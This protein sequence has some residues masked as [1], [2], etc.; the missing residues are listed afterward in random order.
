MFL[1]KKKE[2]FKQGPVLYSALS[3]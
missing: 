1:Q 2:I 3:L